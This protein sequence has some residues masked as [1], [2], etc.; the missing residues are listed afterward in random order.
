VKVQ[1][2][3][4]RLAEAS[5]P[6]LVIG[7]GGKPTA[8]KLS[9]KQVE[10][11]KKA[12]RDLKKAQEATAKLREERS[13]LPELPE[14]ARLPHEIEAARTQAVREA[15]RLLSE[16]TDAP[17]PAE[18]A[19]EIMDRVGLRAKLTPE[20]VAAPRV[21]AETGNS[22]DARTASIADDVAKAIEDDPELRRLVATPAGRNAIASETEIMKI[23]E[24]CKI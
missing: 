23:L 6:T 4:Q 21:S 12:L 3:T 19:A 17:I 8:K 20:Q 11:Q 22:L 2:A 5:K 1:E 24:G 13:R 18:M 16:G 7:K 10:A 14:G 9:R 15:A